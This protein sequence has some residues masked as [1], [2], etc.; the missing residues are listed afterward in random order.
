MLWSITFHERLAVGIAQDAA[1]GACR[2][3]KQD[4]GVCETGGVEL[5]E[6][7]SSKPQAGCARV[8][9]M[10]SPVKS[11]EFDVVEQ[12]AR[13]SGG[14]QHIARVNGLNLARMRIKSHNT[15]RLLAI[16]GEHQIGHIPFLGKPGTLAAA[17]RCHKA[18]RIWWPIWSAA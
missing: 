6:L 12:S 18:C 13:A 5:H 15:G 4:A 8:S 14:Q 1:L 9:A 10:P 3:G 17:H 16:I 2:F 7:M 11:Q